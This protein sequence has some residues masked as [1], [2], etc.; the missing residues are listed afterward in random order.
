M[1]IIEAT[2]VE[3]QGRITPEDT[4]LWS[5]DCIVNLQKV[6]SLVKSQGLVPAIQIAHAGRRAS[7]YSPF[8]G[9]I[10]S[11]VSEELGGWPTDIVGPSANMYGGKYGVS[12]EMAE[13]DME[14]VI[15][16][17]ADADKAGLEVLEIRSA[18]GFLL[19]SFLS[20]NSSKCTD[21]FGS[22][23][24]STSISPWCG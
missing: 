17:F 2:A 1:I 13:Q 18:H 11:V 20:G 7:V 14:Q 6:V 19:H 3:S 24:K 4:S 10:E 9:I 23:W 22:S 8:H 21:I 16:H 5:D 15:Q 12:K